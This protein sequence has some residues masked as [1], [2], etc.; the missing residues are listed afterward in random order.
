MAAKASFWKA[1]GAKLISR[2]GRGPPSLVCHARPRGN[3]AS[4][5]DVNSSS[6][7]QC[8]GYL[9]GNERHGTQ[10]RHLAGEENYV[11]NRRRDLVALLAGRVGNGL[12]D[13]RQRKRRLIGEVGHAAEIVVR[14]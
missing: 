12:P 9:S 14:T 7:G 13:P 6:V 1:F 10:C 5:A 8:M 4:V 3:S 2:P 11:G